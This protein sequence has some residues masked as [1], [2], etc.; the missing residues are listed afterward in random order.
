MKKVILCVN[1]QP[2]VAQAFFNQFENTLGIHIVRNTTGKISDYNLAFT[3][4]KT[5]VDDK[6]IN[7]YITNADISDTDINI[8]YIPYDALLYLIAKDRKEQNKDISYCIASVIE[9]YKTKVISTHLYNFYID[10][11]F[12]ADIGLFKDF[13]NDNIGNE[14]LYSNFDVL[15]NDAKS[16]SSPLLADDI[17]NYISN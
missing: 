11:K 17:I 12:K 5:T 15:F 2:Y 6:D 1:N 8:V 16:L 9:P 14:L 10:S 13:F 4:W 7:N 3:Q